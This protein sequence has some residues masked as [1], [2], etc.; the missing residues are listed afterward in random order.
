MPP[1]HP[2]DAVT[3][4][5][6]RKPHT[7]FRCASVLTTPC[8]NFLWILTAKFLLDCTNAC[9][10]WVTVSV[11]TIQRSQHG[12]RTSDSSLPLIYVQIYGCQI[13]NGKYT[14]PSLFLSQ[15]VPTFTVLR[16]ILHLG[17]E[18]DTCNEVLL[19][20]PENGH[21]PYFNFSSTIRVIQTHGQC[22]SSTQHRS[23][24]SQLSDKYN[25]GRREDQVR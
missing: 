11:R 14:L 20:R 17:V 4:R 15:C 2:I 19:T 8:R 24:Q 6:V 18:Y 10:R 23:L 25:H 3:R 16:H 12:T 1:E 5:L 22:R 13:A 9:Q 7:S 21:T